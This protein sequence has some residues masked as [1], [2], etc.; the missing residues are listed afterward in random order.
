VSTVRLI[1]ERTPPEWSATMQAVMNAS[2]F[3]LAQLVGGPL[4]GVVAGAF[5]LRAVFAGSAAFA[6]LAALVIVLS[7]LRGYFA[8]APASASADS[9]T[10]P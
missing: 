1:Q 9:V 6:A 8:P 3:G 7:A 2:A 5:G 4:A 10:T